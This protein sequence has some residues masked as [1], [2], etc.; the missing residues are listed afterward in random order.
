MS[1]HVSAESQKATTGCEKG[2]SCLMGD[3]KDLCVVEACVDGK[4]HFIKCLNRGYCSYQQP[5]GMGHVCTC[6]TRKELFNKFKI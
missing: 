3:R 5:F 6:P 2:F 1:Y 4:V